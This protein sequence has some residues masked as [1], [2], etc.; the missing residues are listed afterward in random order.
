MGSTGNSN[1]GYWAAGTSQS[2]GQYSSID[3]IEYANDTAVASIRGKVTSNRNGLTASTDGTTYG[4]FIGGYSGTILSSIERITYANDTVT[5]TA[6]GP[7]AVAG[8]KQGGTGS[9]TYGYY[10]GGSGPL[11]NV[12]RITYAT[13]TDV[14]S[15]RGYLAAAVYNQ[16]ASSGIQ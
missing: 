11:S 7:L 8:T 5:A 9:N 2:S 10:G 13:D 12:Q 3:R 4:W 16:A 14:A 6:R 1:Y 15:T